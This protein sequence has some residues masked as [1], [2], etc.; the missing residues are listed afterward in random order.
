M[1]WFVLACQLTIAVGLLNVW[2]LRAQKATP[3]RGGDAKNM[4]EEFS[5]YGL[6]VWFMWAIGLIKVTLAIAL[7]AGLWFTS[8]TKPAAV[9]LALL[10]LCAVVMHIKVRDPLKK[11]LPAMSLLI[12]CL[13]VAFYS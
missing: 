1:K 3:Y 6:P 11:A 5:A 2:L 8:I 4:Q 13:T 7:I 10:M 12:L 9:G